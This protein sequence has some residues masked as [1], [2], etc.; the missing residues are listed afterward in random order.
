MATLTGASTLSNTAVL[1]AVLKA[2]TLRGTTSFYVPAH[3]A[4]TLH[5][6]GE[7]QSLGLVINGEVG[8]VT[9]NFVLPSG[10][11]TRRSPAKKNLSHPYTQALLSAVPIHDPKLEKKRER[12]ILTGDVPNPANP[13]AG[14]HFSTRCPIAKEICFNVSPKWR[15]FSKEHHVSCH[16]V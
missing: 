4:S 5:R 15:E 3:L 6:P 8:Y 11:V 10:T 9:N 16:L 12:I 2:S 7:T 14:C 1:A 13:P